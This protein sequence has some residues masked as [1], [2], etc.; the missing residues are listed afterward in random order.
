MLTNLTCMHTLEK[1]N[2]GILNTCTLCSY[3]CI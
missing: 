3:Y 1:T 2:V